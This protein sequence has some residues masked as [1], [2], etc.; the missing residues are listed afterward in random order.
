MS[1]LKALQQ[2]LIARFPPPPAGKKIAAAVS[3]GCDSVA[4]LLLLRHWCRMRGIGLCVF[5]VDHALRATSERDAR[6]VENLAAALD[7]KFYSRRA[8]PE[9]IAEAGAHGS[10]AWARKFRYESFA[11]LLDESGAEVIATGHTADDQTETIL[12]RLLR[13]SSW[14]GLRG[15]GSRVRL[16][17]A[18]RELLVWRPLLVIPRQELEEYL[19]AAGQSWCDDETNQTDQYFRNRVRRHLLPLLE[20]MQSGALEHIAALGNDARLLH[21]DLRRRARQFL[22]RNGS[23]ESLKVYITPECTLRREIIRAWLY[24]AGLIDKVTRA[25]IIRIDG[26][27]R[28]AQIGNRVVYNDFVVERLSDSLSLKKR[29]A[30]M[31]AENTVKRVQSARVGDRGDFVNLEVEKTLKFNDWSFFLTRVQPSQSDDN[32]SLAVPEDFATH[33]VVRCRQPGDRFY[34]Q[35]GCGGKK[36]SRWLI[37][38]KVPAAVRDVLPLVVSGNTVLL[39]AGLGKSRFL[40]DKN[41]EKPSLWLTVKPSPAS[42]A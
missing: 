23:C 13:G 28:N 15:I 4:M 9:E 3:G 19:R 18:G 1:D 35:G 5:H 11:Q 22:K 34:P 37:D 38:K 21:S 29:S 39:V 41:A 25:L 27:W 20:Q 6:W 17:F 32:Q 7:L 24:S 42:P 33:L 30:V 36:L 14:H 12:M 26:L 10:E 16:A 2:R 8:G 40:A 31:V